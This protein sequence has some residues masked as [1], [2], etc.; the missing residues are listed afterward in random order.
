MEKNLNAVIENI[1]HNEEITKQILYD[2]KLQFTVKVPLQVEKVG[3][4]LNIIV[5][6]SGESKQLGVTSDPSPLLNV[7]Q[8]WLSSTISFSSSNF[9]LYNE[10]LQL[11][12]DPEQLFVV[13]WFARAFISF[14]LVV[15]LPHWCLSEPMRHVHYLSTGPLFDWYFIYFTYI[16]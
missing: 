14:Q 6:F 16:A 3:S 12:S 11:R 1:F 10:I 5:L 4:Q 7:L 13:W 9:S 2:I 8:P 15:E